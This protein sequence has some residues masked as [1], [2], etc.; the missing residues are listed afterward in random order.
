[1]RQ[2]GIVREVTESHAVVE[3]S[4]ESACEGCHA[5]SDGSCAGCVTFGSSKKVTCRAENSVGAAVG[6]R[7]EVETASGVV[8]LYAAAVFLFPLVL[9]I[10]GWFALGMIGE[11]AAY[12]GAIGGFAL[13]FVIVY[14]TLNRTAAKRLDVRILRILS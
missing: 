3:V 2:I 14:F 4:R 11:T 6:N 12:L 13:A 1:M 7:V 10:I 9:G 5:K 8:I